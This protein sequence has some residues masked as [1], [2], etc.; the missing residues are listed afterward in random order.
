MSQ[1]TRYRVYQRGESHRCIGLVTLVSNDKAT[2]EWETKL[3]RGQLCPESVHALD[4]LQRIDIAVGATVVRGSL[5]PAKPIVPSS[6]PFGQVIR[7]LPP[8]D[9][10]PRVP[11]CVVLWDD[12]VNTTQSTLDVIDINWIQPFR[13]PDGMLIDQW[14]LAFERAHHVDLRRDKENEWTCA[15]NVHGDKT[16]ECFL[17]LDVA[18]RL[19][20]IQTSCRCSF[21]IHIDS[22]GRLRLSGAHNL[23]TPGQFMTPDHV[24]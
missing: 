4:R 17:N 12:Q 5:T 20:H 14:T 24:M 21:K 1:E 3:R 15:R 11:Q 18:H 2:V 10:D 19:H 9:D 7:L 22:D 16:C 13:L 6:Q 23:H 8:T